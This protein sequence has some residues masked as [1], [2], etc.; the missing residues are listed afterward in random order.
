MRL[1]KINDEDVL[2]AIAELVF[3]ISKACEQLAI[4]LTGLE[5]SHFSKS[6][7]GANPKACN[8]SC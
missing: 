6:P 5:R 1:D 7:L 2:L 4:T 3:S 8:L